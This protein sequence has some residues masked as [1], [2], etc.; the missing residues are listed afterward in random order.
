[1]TSPT[2]PRECARKMYS[3]THDLVQACK[4]LLVYE[5]FCGV[6]RFQVQEDFTWKTK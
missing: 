6:R 3:I 4:N 1:M 5:S 2:S